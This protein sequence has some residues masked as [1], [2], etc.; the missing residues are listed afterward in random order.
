[1]GSFHHSQKVFG[2]ENSCLLIG[3]QKPL[4]VSTEEH[5]ELGCRKACV[6]TLTHPLAHGLRSFWVPEEPTKCAGSSHCGGWS[7]PLCRPEAL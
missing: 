7:L 3:R 1:M 4:V 6:M 2:N 5:C